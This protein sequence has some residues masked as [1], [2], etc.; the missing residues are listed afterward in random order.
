MRK[1]SLDEISIL[2]SNGC[3]SDSWDSISV[4]DSFDVRYCREVKFIDD[5]TI[6]ENGGTVKVSDSFERHC[7]LFNCTLRNVRIGNDCLIENVRG[8]ISNYT[9]GNGCYISDVYC[10][11][12]TS[13]PSFGEGKVIS[14]LNEVG[15]GNVMIFDGLNSQLAALMVKY[16]QD[17]EFTSKVRSI[18]EDYIAE[19]R[20]KAVNGTIHHNVRIVNT[21]RIINCHIG[22]DCRIEGAQCL[23]ECTLRSLPSAPVCI[24]T[25]VILESTVVY[26][27]STI[28]N[29]SK[30][31]NCFVGEA[32]KITDGFTA[33][34]SL[35]FA[36]NHMA[37]GEACAAF[38]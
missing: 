7:G 16:E 18:V 5:V 17:K 25:G 3:F 29:N 14:V 10:I 19:R 8:Y 22:N 37:N 30:L 28:A 11:E 27:G 9:I 12:T 4:A 15:D 36:N 6:G 13:N 35:F 24:G 33:E 34:S 1:L 21:G 2:E 26:N 31:E 20:K 32:C 23:N 38:C